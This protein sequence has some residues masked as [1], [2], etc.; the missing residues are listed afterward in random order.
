[1]GPFLSELAKRHIAGCL[2]ADVLL[3]V[4]FGGGHGGLHCPDPMAAVGFAAAG[5]AAGRNLIRHKL[6]D[7]EGVLGSVDVEVKAKAEEVV[8]V[9]GVSPWSD[10]MAKF[11]GAAGGVFIGEVRAHALGDVGVGN[12]LDFENAGRANANGDAAVLAEAPVQDVV[13]VA[14]GSDGAQNELASGAAKVAV[15]VAMTPDGVA[16]SAL[17]EAGHLRPLEGRAVF[18]VEEG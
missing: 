4:A 13:V 1:M 10:E 6:V 11:H 5:V 18:L 3:G 14:D 2:H 8:M 9:D 7:H 17:E 16:L 12:W 15:G